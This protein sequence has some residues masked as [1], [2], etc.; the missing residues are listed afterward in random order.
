MPDTI[1]ASGASRSGARVLALRKS[2]VSGIRK[3][4]EISEPFLNH[5]SPSFLTQFRNY[6]RN[7]Q[8]SDSE[9][10]NGKNGSL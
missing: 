1:Q 7:H 2:S 6:V 3:S 8:K 10:R 9:N 4:S 5:F